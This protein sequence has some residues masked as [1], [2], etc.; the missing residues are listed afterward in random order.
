MIRIEPARLKFLLAG[1]V[2]SVE[3]QHMPAREYHKGRSYAV[4]VPGARRAS[5]YAQVLEVDGLTL[6][7][8]NAP[9][10]GD[11][12]RMLRRK[13]GYSS[14]GDPLDAGEAL[15]E[16]EQE[17]QSALGSLRQE[18]ERVLRAAA[19]ERLELSERLRRLERAHG[20]GEL[21]ASRQL[22]AIRRRIEALEAK[23]RAA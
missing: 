22:A 7:L 10:A 17:R 20:R 16:G 14:V 21:D 13:G 1:R 18:Q 2:V 23:R 11:V 15:S 4:A 3:L 8:R 19:V 9:E 5:C 12:P 6:R